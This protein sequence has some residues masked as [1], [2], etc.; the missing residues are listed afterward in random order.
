MEIFISRPTFV[1]SHNTR[2]SSLTPSDLSDVESTSAAP[3][4]LRDNRIK[5]GN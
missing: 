1:I 2:V 3:F 4:D 5:G